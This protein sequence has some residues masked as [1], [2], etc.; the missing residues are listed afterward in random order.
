MLHEDLNKV[1]Q[2]PYLVEKE[3]KPG[4]PEDE[5][6]N[7]VVGNYKLRDDSIIQNMFYGTFRSVTSCPV[8]D[9]MSLKFEPFNM[10]SVSVK[11]TNRSTVFVYHLH[12]FSFYQLTHLKFEVGTDSKL[13]DFPHI[14]EKE[15]GVDMSRATL[16]IY[17]N[18]DFSFRLLSE[19]EKSYSHAD[20]NSR[21][22]MSDYL[23]IVETQS[24]LITGSAGETNVLVYFEIE[25]VDTQ[26]VIGIKKP[27]VVRE[28]I[29]VRDLYHFVYQ[30]VVRIIDQALPSFEVVFELGTKK[31]VP[32]LLL[33]NKEVLHF[34]DHDS[35]YK[36]SLDNASVISVRLKDP[37]LTDCDKFQKVSMMNQAYEGYI[38][39]KTTNITESLESLTTA[40]D[41]DEENKW[42][43]EKCK[44]N[45]KAKVQ[46]KIKKLPPVLIIHLKRFKKTQGGTKN[47]KLDCRVDFPLKDLD[48]SKFTTEPQAAENRLTYKLFAIIH[49]QGSI[50]FGHY[51]STTLSEV[52]SVWTEFNDED[53]RKIDSSKAKNNKISPY[54]LFYRRTSIPP[55]PD[56]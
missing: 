54:I 48:L 33:I 20:K 18:K 24:P 51:Y 49:H 1:L 25:G 31:S 47:E 10:L 29:L 44:E 36:I 4:E 40:E 8:C 41:L 43:C 37:I 19:E 53:V 12:E 34:T 28:F 9:H 42:K 35:D 50:D 52:D 2:K 16:Y 32:F 5:Y 23:F 21:M 13:A 6:Y 17:N 14:Y 27:M 15:K 7:Q 30:C 3:F 26:A 39:G 55:S 22:S 45:R 56:Y 11:D 38:G 46:I